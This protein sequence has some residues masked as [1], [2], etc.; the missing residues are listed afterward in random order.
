LYARLFE[1]RKNQPAFFAGELIR[2]PTTNDNRVFAFARVSGPSKF[3]VVC[4][5]DTSPFS[6][7]IDLSS[8]KLGINNQ[9]SLTDAF[10]SHTVT[11]RLLPSKSTPLEVPAIGFRIVQIEQEPPH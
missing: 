6:G 2:I 4:N 1:L 11:T 8:P 10:S 5:F 7:S 3:I 9:I